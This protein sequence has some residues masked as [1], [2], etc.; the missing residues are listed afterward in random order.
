MSAGFAVTPLA[1]SFG[2]W[3]CLFIGQWETCPQLSDPTFPQLPAFLA[4]RLRWVVTRSKSHR[5]SWA[6]PDWTAMNTK[7]LLADPRRIASALALVCGLLL[8]AWARSGDE[9]P[10]TYVSFTQDFVGTCVSRN[11]V[12]ILVSNSHPTRTLRV[13]LDRF[14]M[15]VGTGDRS[16]SELAPGAEPEPLGCSRSPSGPQEWRVVRAVFVD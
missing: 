6:V 10:A 13:W 2:V 14:H 15:G 8:P 4:R 3:S 5:W 12:Q 7:P 16:K 11:G 9:E 1:Q